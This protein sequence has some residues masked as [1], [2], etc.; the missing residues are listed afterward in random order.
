MFLYRVIDQTVLALPLP[1]ERSPQLPPQRQGA[2][3]I[4][5][6]FGKDD[7]MAA[8]HIRQIFFRRGGNCRGLLRGLSCLRRSL[9]FRRQG[10]TV[11]LR[12][13]FRLRCAASCRGGHPGTAFITKLRIVRQFRTTL[14][15]KH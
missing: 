6:I 11:L 4:D 3:K 8:R 10:R 15:A 14:H 7:R 13:R 9:C 5:M 1:V 12:N 2:W